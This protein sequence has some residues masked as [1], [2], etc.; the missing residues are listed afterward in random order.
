MT[1]IEDQDLFAKL[2][3][4]GLSVN[5]EPPALPALEGGELYFI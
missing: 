5:G 2:P 4:Y 3:N 1:G